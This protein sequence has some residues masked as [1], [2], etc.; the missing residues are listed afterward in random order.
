M[1]RNRFCFMHYAAFNFH[2]C[3]AFLQIYKPIRSS[4]ASYGS[5]LSVV[6][7]YG[8]VF[9]VSSDYKIH[10][11]AVIPSR[12]SIVKPVIHL[13][14]QTSCCVLCAAEFTQRSTK[15]T[16]RFFVKKDIYLIGRQAENIIEREPFESR[17]R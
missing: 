10:M 13:L 14:N 16:H 8:H 9:V 6:A 2:S 15:L 3:T 4:P 12:K 7:F 5:D 17:I 1:R 11:T